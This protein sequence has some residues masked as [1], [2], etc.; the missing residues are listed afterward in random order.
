MKLFDSSRA[1][2]RAALLAVVVA[3]AAGGAS[4]ADE[5]GEDLKALAESVATATVERDAWND[6]AHLAS[7][8]EKAGPFAVDAGNLADATPLGKIALGKVLLAVKER[9]R[10]AQALLKVALSDAPP[11]MKI[12]ALQLV[13]QAG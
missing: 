13:A 1:T 4:A 10:A 5:K 12:E 3:F 7:F 6:A 11:E 9:G 8:G 2:V